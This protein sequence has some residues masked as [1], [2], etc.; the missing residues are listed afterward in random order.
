MIGLYP[1]AKLKIN[2]KSKVQQNQYKKVQIL[3][4]DH[5]TIKL[6]KSL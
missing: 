1:K 2:K 6:N 5:K 4:I 3:I